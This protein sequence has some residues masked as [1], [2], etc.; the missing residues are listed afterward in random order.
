MRIG[1]RCHF[2]AFFLGA[3]DKMKQSKRATA[4]HLRKGITLT[5]LRKLLVVFAAKQM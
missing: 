1:Q 5:T 2:E 4:E 3:C